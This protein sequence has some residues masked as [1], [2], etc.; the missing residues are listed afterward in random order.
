MVMV[1]NRGTFLIYIILQCKESFFN[2]FLS[3]NVPHRFCVRLSVN[4]PTNVFFNPFQSKILSHFFGQT[5]F[6]D[7]FRSFSLKNIKNV[8]YIGGNNISKDDSIFTTVFGIRTKICGDWSSHIELQVTAVQKMPFFFQEFEN[9][10]DRCL[11]DGKKMKSCEK[12]NGGFANTC[13]ARG[14]VVCYL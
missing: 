4:L 9:G 7:F 5:F 3:K 8:H 1:V 6:P 11:L 2:I 10:T 14:R 13:F 12:N